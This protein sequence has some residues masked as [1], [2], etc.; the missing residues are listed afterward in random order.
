M[1]SIL[2]FLL[3]LIIHLEIKCLIEISTEFVDVKKNVITLA[4]D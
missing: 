2:D 1:V 3:I 4:N